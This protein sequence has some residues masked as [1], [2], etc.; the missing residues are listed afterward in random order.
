MMAA[1]ILLKARSLRSQAPSLIQD[2]GCLASA[3]VVHLLCLKIKTI[4]LGPS[5]FNCYTGKEKLKHRLTFSR[6]V[7][8]NHQTA[9]PNTH[10]TE[11]VITKAQKRCWRGL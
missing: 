9:V 6:K 8:A 1:E 2:Q 4:L 7:G 11:H 10:L 3:F 5:L